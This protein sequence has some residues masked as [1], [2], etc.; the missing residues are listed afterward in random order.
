MPSSP[1]R[2]QL[3]ALL[4]RLARYFND[5]ETSISA[6]EVF[7]CYQHLSALETSALNRFFFLLYQDKI[8]VN[9]TS[10]TPP[11]TTTHE[12]GP[13]DGDQQATPAPCQSAT[14]AE[15]HNPTTPSSRRHQSSSVPLAEALQPQNS[16]LSGSEAASIRSQRTRYDRRPLQLPQLEQPPIS[17][18]D[19]LDTY[20]ASHHRRGQHSAERTAHRGPEVGFSIGH[21]GP[22]MSIVNPQLQEAAAAIAT[23][24]GSLESEACTRITFASCT[25]IKFK[26]S[27][28]ELLKKCKYHPEEFLYAIREAKAV[29]PTGQG[30]EAAIATK[31]ENADVR[32]LMKIY[33]RFECHN[34][35]KHVVEAG[36]HTGEHWIRNMRTTLI[37]KLCRDIPERFHDAKTANKCLNWVDQGCKFQEWAQA[38]SG[39]ETDLGYLIALPSDIP[40]SAYTSRCTKEQLAPALAKFKKL[41][42]TEMVKS[43]KLSAL[44]AHVSQTLR[45]MTTRKRREDVSSS[46]CYKSPIPSRTSDELALTLLA[47][48]DGTMLPEPTTQSTLE[49]T[50]PRSHSKLLSMLNLA[51]K[52]GSTRHALAT[53][54]MPV[55][56]G[57]LDTYLRHRS[58]SEDI[59]MGGQ[60]DFFPCYVSEGFTP[61][62]MNI[63]GEHGL[64]FA[65]H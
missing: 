62:N 37:E 65:Y 20:G 1:S 45:E 11:T 44:G 31:K 26:P 59:F 63:A 40:H 34:I 12:I 5:N 48:D 16:S 39:K 18:T 24:D 8:D 21:S 42:I 25:E 38:L 7:T 58:E 35:Y 4:A 33:H 27:T 43:L 46:L 13:A 41:G 30:W 49:L 6:E 53:T 22:A 32:D 47:T 29:L 50:R 23:L 10:I 17:N 54:S 2:T 3:Q 55:E 51:A 9:R 19:G 28:L 57:D 52:T 14:M 61:G 56:G 60:E 36:F 15:A 64:L